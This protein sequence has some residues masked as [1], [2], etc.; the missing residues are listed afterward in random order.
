M[1][2]V[3]EELA[4]LHWTADD[5]IGARLTWQ[6][7]DGETLAGEVIGIVGR[8][9]W[10]G[11][12]QNPPASAYWWFPSA[13]AR[14]L[15]IVACTSG[16]VSTV[17]RTIAARV[18]E[19]DRNQPVAFVRALGDFVADDLA[20]PRF[21]MVLLLVFAVAAASLAAV[22][23]YGV[24][25]CWASERRRE[26]GL[27]MALGAER[28]DVLGLVMRRSLLLV[29]AGL[30]IGGVAA[31]AAGRL[32]AGVIAGLVSFDL[33]TLTAA[34]GLLA[35]IATVAAYLPARRAAAL[36]PLVALRAD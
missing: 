16:S 36:N 15:T 23:L 5:P 3:D 13:P 28:A 21:T 26:I 31:L 17:A 2:V 20:R 35:G 34:A 18:Q 29:G 12:G 32:V 30:G 27:R 19:I 33:V 10:Q 11:L 1:F 8:V 24:V 25:A 4:R 9:R 7:Q 22:G 14:D 6:R